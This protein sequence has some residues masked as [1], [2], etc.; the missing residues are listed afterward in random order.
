MALA[1]MYP[2]AALF[3]TPKRQ[4]K[5]KT[6]KTNKKNRKRCVAAAACL[7][8]LVGTQTPKRGYSPGKIGV[9][10]APTLT[11]TQSSS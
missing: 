8:L 3:E 1:S 6:P 7:F 9:V 10:T 2:S 4:K 11:Y 5:T